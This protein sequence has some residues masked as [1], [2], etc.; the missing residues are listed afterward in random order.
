MRDLLRNILGVLL[1]VW[2]PSLLAV[3]SWQLLATPPMRPFAPLMQSVLQQAGISATVRYV[4][5]ARLI[6]E[7]QTGRGDGAFFLTER[8]RD[9][10]PAL[11]IVPVALHQYDLMAVSLKPLAA[12]TPDALA[13][14]RL[15]IE[16]GNQLSEAWSVN[17]PRVYRGNSVP[18][19]VQAFAAGRFDVL[20]LGRDQVAR[21]LNRVKIA[22]YYLHEP[23]LQSMPLYLMLLPHRRGALPAVTKAFQQ[24]VDSGAW[25]R[26]MSQVLQQYAR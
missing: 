8:A 20:V 16:R 13:R 15:G 11:E 7:L 1:L 21:Q 4:P 3:E 12:T 18:K 2:C 19:L 25:S 23:P 22:V 14:Y 26:Q 24:A 9:S 5:Q 17:Y 10:V 6:A